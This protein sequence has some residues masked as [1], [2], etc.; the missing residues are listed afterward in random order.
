[1]RKY[2]D[3]PDRSLGY[4]LGNIAKARRDDPP[5]STPPFLDVPVDDIGGKERFTTRLGERLTLSGV[6]IDAT[7]AA[8]DR[9]RSA[10][11][12]IVLDQTKAETFRLI[13]KPSLAA[14]I[15]RSRSSRNA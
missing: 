10:A 3:R 2:R 1:M 12:H 5:I 4:E 8:R 13:S 14:M 7:P 6:M 9:M 15:A 11:L